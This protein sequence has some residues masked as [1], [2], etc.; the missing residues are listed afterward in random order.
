M[1]IS[2]LNKKY[3]KHAKMVET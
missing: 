3:S 1:M 2:Q